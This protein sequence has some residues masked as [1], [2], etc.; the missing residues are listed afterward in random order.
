MI[1]RSAGQQGFVR[2]L[3]PAHPFKRLRFESG[4]FASIIVNHEYIQLDH[5]VGVIMPQLQQRVTVAQRDA[6]FLA[7]FA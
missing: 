6:E 7:Q 4:G 1:G 5:P 3:L 2:Q